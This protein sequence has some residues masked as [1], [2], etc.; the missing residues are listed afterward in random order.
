[1]I[2]VYVAVFSILSSL[3]LNLLLIKSN[4]LLDKKYSDHKLFASEKLIPLS[5]GLII[6]L[7]IFIFFELDLLLKGILFLIL[8]VG[9]FSDTNYLFSPLKR[10]FLQ[11]LFF[12]VFLYLSQSFIESVRIPIFD[13][14]LE[15]FYFKYF[16][17][18]L[19]FLILV[20]GTN[21]IDGL[22]TLA[23]GYFLMIVGITIYVNYHFEIGHESQMF[24]I[25]LI[26]LSI[27]FFFNL[28]NKL[29]L[30]DS[31]SYLISFLIGYLLIDFSNYSVRVSPYFVA[32][33]LWYPA[34]ENLFS[35]IRK[36]I[37][38]IPV[39]FADNKHLHQLFFRFIHK[40]FLI[41]FQE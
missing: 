39:T 5:G 19:C 6:L 17:T 4:F 10:L 14:F 24:E 15:N 38:K 25:L 8:I 32:V 27:L 7:T 33:L 41:L 26:V 16:F 1:M 9:I 3:I 23:I 28:F 30:G 36:K 34:Y 40:K 20:N 2:E 29:Y 37:S 22:N 31:G 13:R 35:I 18:L 11:I 21:F 12:F